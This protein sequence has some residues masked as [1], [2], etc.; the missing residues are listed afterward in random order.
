[1]FKWFKEHVKICYVIYLFIV[2]VIG[3]VFCLTYKKPNISYSI[4]FEAIY[5][6]F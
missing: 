2:I 4:E 3:V 1:M 5:I 6:I